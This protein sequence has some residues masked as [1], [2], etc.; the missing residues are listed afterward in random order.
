MSDY[1]DSFSDS[2][3]QDFSNFIE[4]KNK[5]ID[6]YHLFYLLGKGSY[7]QVW[8]AYNHIKKDFY[9][10]KI[11]HPDDLEAAK[12]ELKILK[13]IEKVPYKIKVIENFIFAKVNNILI[14]NPK[15]NNLKEKYYTMVFPVYGSNLDGLLKLE[16][17]KNGFNDS[18]VKKF[19][20]ETLENLI[21]LHDKY[22]LIHCDIKPDN[23]LLSYPDF[24]IKKIME[25][26]NQYKFFEIYKKVL[27]KKPEL[28]K[29]KETDINTREQIHKEIIKEIDFDKIL[30]IKVTEKEIFE[31]LDK[32]NFLIS[33]FGNFC[34]IEEKYDED[35]GTRYY[36][37]PENILV[38]KDLNYATDIW[39]LGCTIYEL[40]T[41]SILFDPIKCKKYTTDHYHLSEIFQ[42][43]KLSNKEIKSLQRKKEFFKKDKSCI[44]LPKTE[45]IIEKINKIN[46][47][48]WKG[49]ILSI[50]CVSYKKRPTC[51]QLLI[52]M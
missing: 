37:S 16:I 9:A 18:L 47:V 36:R 30:N 33:D 20:K 21:I 17:F 13:Q 51:R 32:S 46:N 6:D 10:L 45:S 50:L 12:E 31:Q 34:N 8:L 24:Q 29:N 52:Q 39:S 40:L 44:K 41:N 38:S 7:A 19:T 23:F 1:S 43:G 14:K 4:L 42:L 26:Y 25:S 35:F 5:V 27:Y 48:F 22:N 28:K 49:F 3:K 11:Q 15:K 2:D